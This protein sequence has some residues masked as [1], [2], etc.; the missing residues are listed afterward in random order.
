[1]TLPRAAQPLPAPESRTGAATAIA[2]P[3]R[4]LVVDDNI[5]AATTLAEVLRVEGHH[6]RVAFSAAQALES[7]ARDAALDVC[8]LD[9][10]LPDMT[11]HALAARLREQL[12][13]RPVRFIALT[14]YGQAEDRARSAEAGFHHHFVKPA[15]VRQLLEALQARG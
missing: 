11:G 2:G 13:P 10:G 9:I 5:D 12:G 7:V 14:G 6:V 1:V 3:K 8:I 4:V 15:D